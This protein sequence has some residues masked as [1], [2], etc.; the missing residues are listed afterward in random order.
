MSS[1]AL[2][3][4][5]DS[6]G[7]PIAPWWHT[8]LV[9]A[10]IAIGSVAS[11]HQHGLEHVSVPGLSIRLSGYFTVLV[12]EWFVVLLI[13]LALRRRGL[14][15]ASLVSGRWPTPG[16]FF[17]DLGLA[18]G[19]VVVIILLLSFLPYLLGAR[20]DSSLANITPKTGFEVVVWLGLSATAGFG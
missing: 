20:P 16:A 13:W 12:Q 11:A 18:V 15:L 4:S 8:V 3:M 10:P 19:F 14:S 1:S 9:L 17:K 6:A 7:K 2:T 5:A